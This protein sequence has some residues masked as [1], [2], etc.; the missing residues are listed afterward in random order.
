M[1]VAFTYD[2]ISLSAEQGM[3]IADALASC[4]IAHGNHSMRL[5]RFR[6]TPHPIRETPEAWLTVDGIPNVNPY[7]TAIRQGMCIRSQTSR[8]LTD[9]LAKHTY[10]GF[11]FDAFPHSA[12]GRAALHHVI[13][14]NSD[15]GGHLPC[16]ATPV[17]EQSRVERM[18]A[19]LLIVGAGNAGMAALTA[20]PEGTVIVDA[21]DA[22][23]LSENYA[24]VTGALTSYFS[25][26]MPAP[27]LDELL[28]RKKI[29]LL[30]GSVIF[31]IYEGALFA[32]LTE[33]RRIT[34][35]HAPKVVIATGSEEVLPIFGN[36]DISGIYSA[37]QLSFFP[38]KLKGKAAV[39]V[40]GVISRSRIR[41]LC[42][43]IEAPV[44]LCSRG[45]SESSLRMLDDILSPCEIVRGCT[46]T[47]AEDRNALS[48]L[49][50]ERM[51]EERRL[52]LD[53]LIVCGRLQPRL[54]LYKIMMAMHSFHEVDD[55]S[56]YLCGSAANL[57]YPASLVSG[58]R[59]VQAVNAGV[60]TSEYE[61]SIRSEFP[62]YSSDWKDSLGESAPVND[63]VICPCT[64][65]RISDI[66]HAYYRGYDT[67][68]R[69]KRYTGLFTGPCQGARCLR[70]AAEVYS[71]IS[72]AEPDFPTP[73]SPLFPVQI[74]AL[75][76]LEE[77]MFLHD[78]EC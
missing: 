50:F 78:A 8:H 17:W 52:S 33:G 16:D 56:P 30:S 58:L 37:Q 48:A 44:L 26:D 38:R 67:L 1:K 73:R 34:L 49:H 4:G 72:G 13:R 18:N 7:S 14:R 47:G 54:E 62:S 59:A 41:H 74:G 6:N 27:T 25:E 5:R 32:A 53:T 55:C 66:I 75:A 24:E 77:D 31:G 23:V 57:S 21:R 11:Y 60:S 63:C 15:Q 42:P 45:T 51:G 71:F 36:N 46:L 70:N 43:Q 10:A 40:E 2:G 35:I 3:S 20:A 65:V 64:D 29:R 61:R 9:L 68:N 76:E 12:I 39:Y 22:S 19:G 28:Q 69:I